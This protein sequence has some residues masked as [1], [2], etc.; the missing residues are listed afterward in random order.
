MELTGIFE[1]CH[2]NYVRG[3]THNDKECG[4]ES[5]CAWEHSLGLPMAV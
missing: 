5:L 2:E 1:A 4:F 3:D